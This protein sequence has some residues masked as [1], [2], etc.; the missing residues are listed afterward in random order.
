MSKNRTESAANRAVTAAPVTESILDAQETKAQ[1]DADRLLQLIASTNEFESLV[2]DLE[3]G[4][5]GSVVRVSTLDFLPWGNFAYR[6]RIDNA[7]I[8][9]WLDGEEEKSCPILHV[10][11]VDGSNRDAKSR[12]GKPFRMSVHYSIASAILESFGRAGERNVM[13]SLSDIIRQEPKRI[14]EQGW[15]MVIAIACDDSGIPLKKQ[16]KRGRQVLADCKVA[17]G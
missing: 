12:V 7:E 11:V 9:T 8:F 10:T 17:I 15:S 5:K 16:T 3:K 6:L 2:K 1:D 13:K 4:A 14:A